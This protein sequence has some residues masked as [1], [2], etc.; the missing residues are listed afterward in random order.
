MKILNEMPYIQYHGINFDMMFEEFQ[1]KEEIM[2]FISSIF[3][4]KQ[5]KD[6][7]NDVIQLKT[8]N[9]RQDFLESLRKS[10]MFMNAV[11][12][13][14]TQSEKELLDIIINSSFHN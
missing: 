4:G 10:S 13:L 6:K 7:Y 14:F 8:F 1:T 11:K 5:V 3:S 9:D 12:N 2:N